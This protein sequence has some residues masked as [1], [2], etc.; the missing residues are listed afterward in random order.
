MIPF[1]SKMGDV[2]MS[3]NNIDS[4]RSMSQ[5]LKDK[6]EDKSFVNPA[7]QQVPTITLNDSTLELNE[8]QDTY[9]ESGDANTTTPAYDASVGEIIVYIGVNITTFGREIPLFEHLPVLPF[10]HLKC[11][12]FCV[13]RIDRAMY[14]FVIFCVFR[15]FEI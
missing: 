9:Y 12:V 1:A 15:L 8:D 7:A 13:F 14:L 5:L 2:T 10:F 3:N 4:V 6:Q 11:S